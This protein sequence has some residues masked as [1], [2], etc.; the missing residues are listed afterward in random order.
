MVRTKKQQQGDFGETES[1]AEDIANGYEIK[2]TK[3]NN[4]GYDYQRRKIDWDE[5]GIA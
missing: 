3:K 1:I 5:V 2:E 4:K